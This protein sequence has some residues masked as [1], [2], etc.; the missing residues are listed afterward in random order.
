M[1]KR[2]KMENVFFCCCEKHHA[3][4]SLLL[5]YMLLSFSILLYVYPIHSNI[6]C[7]KWNNL[8]EYWLKYQERKNLHL[9]SSLNIQ[10]ALFILILHMALN[11]THCK[12]RE[13]SQFDLVYACICVHI[14]MCISVYAS[15]YLY[16]CAMVPADTSL[17][18]WYL[19]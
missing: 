18:F 8:P 11:H 4:I 14:W 15:M 16:V 2:D 17:C 6:S 10:C 12:T 13:A 7:I 19:L 1:G 9:I 5:V 3:T